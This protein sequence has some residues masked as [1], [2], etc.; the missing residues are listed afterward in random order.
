MR[1]FFIQLHRLAMV[2]R[3]ALAILMHFAKVDLSRDNLLIGGFEEPLRRLCVVLRHT[4]AM[5]VHGAEDALAVGVSRLS[6]W[7]YLTKR[8]RIVPALYGCQSFIES[9]P[10][11]YGHY[12]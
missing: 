4:L 5:V 6:H 1:G 11:R 3:K 12:K 7:P 8:G 2:L 10:C 9:C